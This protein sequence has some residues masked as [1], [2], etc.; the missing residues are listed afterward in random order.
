MEEL[1]NDLSI[2]NLDENDLLEY[3]ITNILKIDKLI[4]KCGSNSDLLNAVYNKINLLKLEGLDIIINDI[5]LLTVEHFNLIL[6][7]KVDKLTLYFHKPFPLEKINYTELDLINITTTH[8]TI[9]YAGLPTILEILKYYNGNLF[10]SEVLNDM[11][12]EQLNHLCQFNLRMI[13][14]PL[15]TANSYFLDCQRIKFKIEE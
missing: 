3:N 9:K 6:K 14:F 1:L 2:N 5:S 11:Q 13:N 10:I 12:L 15:R 7:L 4:N 8:L